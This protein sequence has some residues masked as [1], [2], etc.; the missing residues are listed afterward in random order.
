MNSV[1][2]EI[3]DENISEFGKSQDINEINDMSDELRKKY[4]SEL[5]ATTTINGKEKIIFPAACA[6]AALGMSMEEI[7][8]PAK[9]SKFIGD[10]FCFS[11][12]L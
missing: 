1:V 12:F 11:L 8:S 3:S 7:S 2:R 5:L 6:A 9:K 4:A 10:Y